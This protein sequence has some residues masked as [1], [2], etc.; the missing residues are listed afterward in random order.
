M[1]RC[2]ARLKIRTNL[3]MILISSIRTID[4]A[5]LIQA[6]YSKIHYK[7]LLSTIIMILNNLIIQKV[8]Y[9]IDIQNHVHNFQVFQSLTGHYLNNI[10]Y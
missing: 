7:Y 8:S 9:E 2:Y 5:F 10:N 1:C 3:L 6:S 4:L